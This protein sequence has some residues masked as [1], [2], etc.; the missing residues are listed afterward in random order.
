MKKNEE[1]AVRRINR[2]EGNS[3]RNRS[4]QQEEAELS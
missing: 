2:I 4:Q 1:I 3:Q